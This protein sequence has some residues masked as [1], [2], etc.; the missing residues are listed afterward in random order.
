MSSVFRRKMSPFAF[1][2]L[3]IKRSSPHDFRDRFLGT[4][5]SSGDR[6]R[7][8]NMGVIACALT[9]AAWTPS[10]FLSS[11]GQQVIYIP[12]PW[13]RARSEFERVQ[14]AIHASKPSRRK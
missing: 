11:N 9:M 3:T 13:R 1:A 14:R 10:S 2:S 12:R 6:L 5:D 8:M 7:S 4:G